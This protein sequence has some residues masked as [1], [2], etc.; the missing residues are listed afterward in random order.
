MG[1]TGNT[2]AKQVHEERSI[3]QANAVASIEAD[4]FVQALIQDFDAEI[5]PNSIKPIQ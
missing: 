2:I 4:G 1:G 3:A 5:V